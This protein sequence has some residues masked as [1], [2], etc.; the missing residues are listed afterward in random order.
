MT[1]M[2]ILTAYNSIN[3]GRQVVTFDEAANHCIQRGMLLFEK[4]MDECIT[5]LVH[6]AMDSIKA[7]MDNTLRY[8]VR[9][10]LLYG[11]FWIMQ[12]AFSWHWPYS[13]DEYDRLSSNPDF[14]HWKDLLFDIEYLRP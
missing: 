14:M 4:P 6:R 12:E 5:S 9:V 1:T 11:A 7:A 2:E 10:L 13:P 8:D 3:N